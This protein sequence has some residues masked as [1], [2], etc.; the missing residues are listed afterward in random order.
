M[1]KADF[2]LKYLLVNKLLW[3]FCQALDLDY[4]Y[5][6]GV[7]SKHYNASLTI[8]RALS[9]VIPPTQWYEEANAEFCKMIKKDIS[10]LFMHKT[11]KDI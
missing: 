3:P 4:R 9:P 5:I 6:H 11:L 10:T 8:Q 2:V 7:A 1:K